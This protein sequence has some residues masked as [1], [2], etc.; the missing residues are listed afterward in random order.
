MQKAPESEELLLSHETTKSDVQPRSQLSEVISFLAF[1]GHSARVGLAIL[2]CLV[3]FLLA[4]ALV[5][6]QAIEIPKQW[7]SLYSWFLACGLAVG[8]EQKFLAKSL[9]IY[10]NT[11]KMALSG[12][13][14]NALSHLAQIAPDSAGLVRCPASLYHL[15]RAEI[16]AQSGN[17]EL[18]EYELEIAKPAGVK[19]EQYHLAKAG[20]YKAKGEVDAAKNELEKLEALIGFVPA[21]SLE[22][23]LL[24]LEEPRNVWEA[25]KELDKLLELPDGPH[26]TGENTSTLANAYRNVTKLWTGHAEEGLDG[27][28]DAIHRIKA[29][30]LYVDSL[31]PILAS[32]CI[33][34]AYYLATHKEPDAAVEDLKTSSLLCNFPSQQKRREAVKEE[35]EWRHNKTL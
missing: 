1:E 34:R 30:A 5:P 16:L 26:F 12:E 14:E 10:R 22:K 7:Q 33:E 2:T 27:L 35:L 13:Y 24:L 23:T 15:R 3:L 6:W 8:I 31:R 21:I 19:Q 18:A 20:L 29:A 25:K 17:F 9:Y 4:Q 28:N 11:Y 32:L